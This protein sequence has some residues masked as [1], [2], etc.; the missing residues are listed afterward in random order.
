MHIKGTPDTMQKNPTYNDVVKEVLDCFIAKVDE[1]KKAGIVDIIIDPGF[2]F[3]KTIT[4]NFQLLKN[5]HVFSML[6]KP[7][8]AG[9]SRKSTIYKTLNTSA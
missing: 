7:I 1:C 3:G 6:E 5:L 4:H 9:I 2:G 8:L